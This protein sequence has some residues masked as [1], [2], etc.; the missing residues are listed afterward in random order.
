MFTDTLSIKKF[1]EAGKATI[2]IK[3]LKTNK[4]YTYKFIK[5]KNFKNI[6]FVKLMTGTDNCSSFS[7]IGI[8]DNRNGG[9]KLTKKS[10]LPIDSVP[11][12]A[13]NYFLYSLKE[14][15]IPSTLNV[16]HDGKCGRCG[17]KLTTPQ[18]LETGYGPECITKI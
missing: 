16:Y 11:V 17:R 7:Y 5:P 14:N 18:S 2:T 10:K 4:H 3:S 13:M 9:F 8:Y 15:I 6:Y 1:I 12:K